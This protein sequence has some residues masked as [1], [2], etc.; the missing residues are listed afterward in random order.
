[1]YLG[2]IILY[3]TQNGL[4]L[5][6]NFFFNLFVIL[7][8]LCGC[9]PSSDASGAFTDARLIFDHPGYYQIHSQD[10]TTA[11]LEVNGIDE[12]QLTYRNQTY[13]FWF[14]ESEKGKQFTIY[15]YVPYQSDRYSTQ[16]IMLINTKNKTE[17]QK[18]VKSLELVAQNSQNAD[19]NAITSETLEQNLLY[20][21][22]SGMEDPFL[23]TE[24]GGK[25]F[26][27]TVPLKESS[28]SSIQLDFKL[29]SPTTAPVEKDHGITLTI[30]GINGGNFEWKGSGFHQ[31][32]FQIPVKELI[33]SLDI[34]L[35]LKAPQGVIAQRIYLDQIEIQ[36]TE[37]LNLEDSILNISGNGN[38]FHFENCTSFGYLIE[39]EKKHWAISAKA[40]EPGKEF[41]LESKKGNTYDW[42]P[43]KSFQKNATILPFT[44]SDRMYPDQSVDWLVIMPNS[45]K[46]ALEPLVIHRQEQGLETLVVD[47][48]QLYETFSGGFPD[49]LAFQSYFIALKQ[50]FGSFPKYV[51]LVGD[52]SYERKD[53]QSSLSFVPSVWIQSDLIGETTSDMPLMD[54]DGDKKPDLVIGRI[55]TNNANLLK[56]W[57][58]KVI[59]TETSLTALKDRQIVA[60]S[61]GQEMYFAE[62]AK[63]FADGFQHPF[64]ATTINIAK[65]QE[66]ANHLLKQKLNESVY[67][68]AYFGHGSID[69]WGKDKIITIDDINSMSEQK[70][71]P[72]VVNLTCLTG[73]YI[74]PKQESLT[75]ALL[76]K[77]GAGAITVLAP[78]SL[79]SAVYQAELRNQLVIAL[80][81]SQ[82]NHIGDVLMD[83][84]SEMNSESAPI[85]E[86]ML[87]FG[88]FG[89]PANILSQ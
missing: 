39:R 84:W 21:P 29:W 16:Q 40:I 80:Q 70:T 79:T 23:W 4:R 60:I 72:I 64:V 15:F 62:D 50:K 77:K 33:N 73:Y 89:D 48:Q 66:N 25:P 54:I 3:K 17:M 38:N 27:L 30:N 76:F 10:L 83:S 56:N 2:I 61:D 5:K 7:F 75:E 52:F 67:L 37:P 20:M 47:P 34:K 26:E 41:D 59:T 9:F 86:V 65:N 6:K 82:N 78:T 87:T 32:Q 19:E 49:P 1:M 28:I 44:K 81:Q 35:S 45:F 69:S 18:V 63:S 43:E 8:L 14:E 22:K 36:K 12:I 11:G 24:I 88:L 71:I 13:P 57:V 68:L 31:I 51:L 42:I 58:E 85:W 55:P 74:E 53:Y 46:P